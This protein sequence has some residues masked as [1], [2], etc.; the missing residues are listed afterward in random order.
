VFGYRT[1]ASAKSFFGEEKYTQEVDAAI[2]VTEALRNAGYQIACY[3]YKN[4]AYGSYSTSQIL[5]DLDSWRAEVSPILGVVDTLVYARNSDIAGHDSAYSGDKFTV[6]SE[7]GFTNFLG[8]CNGGTP[9]LYAQ[10]SYLRQG[11]ILVS[12][13]NLTD[14]PNWFAGFL[15]PPSVL[16]PTR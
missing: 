5:S 7:F 12:G 9:W 14:H 8:F 3:T 13:S 16:D 15:D 1:N 10:D 11:R 2:K 6:L 4:A